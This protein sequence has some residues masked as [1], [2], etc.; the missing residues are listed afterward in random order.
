VLPSRGDRKGAELHSICQVPDSFSWRFPSVSENNQN[1]RVSA[2]IFVDAIL[3]FSG[4][5][6]LIE[7]SSGDYDSLASRLSEESP[8]YSVLKNGVEIC[9]TEAGRLPETIMIVCEEDEAESLLQVSQELCAGAAAQ[10]EES[11]NL[12]QPN[13]EPADYNDIATQSLRR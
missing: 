1:F 5:K 3:R 8:V 10:I 13:F 12:S 7:I 9:S 2:L 11:I 6:I 4:L